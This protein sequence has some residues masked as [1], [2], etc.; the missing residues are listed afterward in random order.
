MHNQYILEDLSRQ[1]QQERR[2]T[3]QQSG[4]LERWR[5]RRAQRNE[6]LH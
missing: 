3:A 4:W 2:A 1:W 6:R 5:A